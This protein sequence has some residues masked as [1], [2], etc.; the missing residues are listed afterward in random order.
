MPVWPNIFSLK[1]FFECLSLLT[2]SPFSDLTEKCFVSVT[3]EYWEML[4]KLKIK[5][6]EC[7]QPSPL[8]PL[9]LPSF[10]MER[11]YLCWA[12]ITVRVTVVFSFQSCQASSMKIVFFYA[13]PPSTIL[14]QK[15]FFIP[16][17]FSIFSKKSIFESA[18]PKILS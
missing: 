3:F 18:S 8:S 5:I 10:F 12:N 14:S 1:S 9:D 16:V 7:W 11:D 17:P 15:H 13:S 4:K 6:V 2:N